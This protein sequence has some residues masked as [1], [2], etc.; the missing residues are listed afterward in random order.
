MSKLSCHIVQDLLPLYADNLVSEE[1]A[2]DIEEHLQECEECSRMFS[3]MKEERTVHTEPETERKQIDYLKKVKRYM[4][5]TIACVCAAVILV[6]AVPFI[7]FFVTGQKEN[8]LIYTVRVNGKLAEIDMMETSSALCIAGTKVAE[9]DGV[10]TVSAREV[11]PLI[12]RS[13]DAHVA[14]T[15]EQEIRK[16]TTESGKVLYEDGIVISERANSIYQNKQK[17]VGNASGVSQLLNAA[18]A[19]KGEYL[20]DCREI[21]LQTEKEPYGVILFETEKGW[22]STSRSRRDLAALMIAGIS[23][24]SEVTFRMAEGAEYTYSVQDLNG[25]LGRNIKSFSGSPLEVQKLLDLL[26]EN[27]ADKSF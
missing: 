5:K 10:L 16:I 6:A 17:Y 7:R 19:V 3:E 13:G 26:A 14:Y 21:K 27:T 1:T 18:N 23:N 20:F 2:A 24:L 12:Y 4:K 8:S 9:K 11:L 25:L 22:R 15:A